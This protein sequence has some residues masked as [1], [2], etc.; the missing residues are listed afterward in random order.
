MHGS[1]YGVLLE[2]S[3]CCS[4]DQN[5]EQL[6][7]EVMLAKDKNKNVLRTICK[8]LFCFCIQFSARMVE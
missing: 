2:E 6:G 3:P 7:G 8:N 4:G 1:W 5:S